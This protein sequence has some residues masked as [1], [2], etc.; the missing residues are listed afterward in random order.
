MSFLKNIKGVIKNNKKIVENYFFMTLLQ[1][2]NTLFY[3]LIYPYL[4]R[5]LG[6]E[7]YGLYVFASSIA[8][9]FIFFINFGFDLPATKLIAENVNN[10]KILERVLSE[11]F[12]AKNYL[13]LISIIVFAILLFSIPLFWNNKWI[14]ISCFSTVYSYILF[15]QWFFQGIQQM[16]VQTILQLAV[17]ILS[18]PFIFVFVKEKE[19]LMLYSFIVAGTT[20]LA[21]IISFVIIQIKYQLY[22]SWIALKEVKEVF[23]KSLPFFYSYLAGTLKEYSIP[24]IIGALFGM[25]EVAIY[26]LANKIIYIPRVIFMSINAAI[27]PKI[28][29]D[30]NANA[31]KKIIRWEYVLSVITMAG[32][33]LLGGYA[34]HLLG[35]DSMAEAHYMAI[36]LSSTILSR[37]IVGAYTYFV[38]IPNDKNFLVTKTQL[39]ALVSFV[40]SA[41]VLL[42]NRSIFTIGIMI[43]ISALSEI[44]YCLYATSKYKLLLNTTEDENS[45]FRK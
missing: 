13:F 31:I 19:D 36:L 14:F 10:K 9:Y 35:G 18:L 23:N 28:V 15:P 41:F 6:G 3:L 44:I 21:G 17:K 22:V 25:K 11:V 33:A 40:I 7:G 1:F 16:R 20:I 24:V 5:V 2:L 4:I 27:F 42:F 26:D 45:T 12:T 37:L 29:V 43:T 39:I 30:N 32:I 38:F 8:A 34:V